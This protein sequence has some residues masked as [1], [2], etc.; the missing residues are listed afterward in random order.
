M[1]FAMEERFEVTVSALKAR[2]VWLLNKTVLR[3]RCVVSLSVIF[4]YLVFL[5]YLAVFCGLSCCEID[6]NLLLYQM[7]FDYAVIFFIAF[8]SK[9]YGI[10]T[11]QKIKKKHRKKGWSQVT[12]KLNIFVKRVKTHETTGWSPSEFASQ[13]KSNQ[14][15]TTLR[16][17]QSLSISQVL[18]IHSIEYEILVC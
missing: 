16:G 4:G 12:S 13:G 14:L 7:I 6:E 9:L 3:V 8:D 1:I 17:L 5:L 10:R 18:I 11:N 15:K 2:N